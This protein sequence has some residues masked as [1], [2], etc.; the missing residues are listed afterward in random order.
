M[1]IVVFDN[2]HERYEELHSRIEQYFSQYTIRGFETA[3]SLVTYIYDE[4][5]GNVDL[6]F[7]NISE[8]K[9]ENISLAIDIQ[10]YFPHIHIIFY[11]HKSDCA[12][13]IF[14]AVPSYFL[15]YPF[16]EDKVEKSIQRVV[17]NI[18]LEMKQRLSFTH[19]GQV[20]KIRLNSINYIE[21]NGRKLCIYSQDGM[22]EVN[23]TLDEMMTKL[24]EQ[25]EKCH[26]SYIVNL[27][28]ILKVSNEEIELFDHQLVPIA[29]ARMHQMRERFEEYSIGRNVQC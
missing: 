28:K 12:E 20:F 2:L 19:K 21:S 5:K 22:W 9:E 29:R 23:M 26:R 17:D 14:E 4:A 27:D 11:S 15:L 25:F 16:K 18:N 3:F 6:L 1:K 7:I 13:E 24:P 8:N 10:E